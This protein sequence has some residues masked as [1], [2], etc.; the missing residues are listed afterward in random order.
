MEGLRAHG[1]EVV[2]SAPAEMVSADDPPEIREAAH[3]PEELPQKIFSIVPDVVI[4]EQWGLVTYLPAM[5]IPLAIDLHG[6]LSLENAFKKGGNFR[7][8]ALTKIDALARADLLIV[9]GRAQKQYFLTWALLGGADPLDPPFV[10]VPVSMD[11][12]RRPS[13]KSTPPR[14]VFGGATWPWIDPFDALEIAGREAGNVKGAELALYVGEPKL[15]QDHPLYEINKGIYADYKERLKGLQAVKHH[16]LIPHDKLLKVYAGSRA[17]MDVYRPNPERELAFSTRTVEY[18]RCGLPIITGRSMELAEPVERYD[19]GWVVDETSEKE[20]ADAVREALTDEGKARTKSANALRLAGALFDHEHATK[21]LAQWV[22]KPAI[23]K[24]GKKSLLSDFRDYYRRESVALIDKAQDKVAKI[25]EEM[26]AI[27]SEFQRQLA[28]KEDRYEALAADMRKRHAE[29]DAQI[30]A[31]TQEHQERLTETRRDVLR[32]QDKLDEQQSK[33]DERVKQ[34]DQDAKETIK[35]LQEEIRHL[36]RE[37]QADQRRKDQEIARLQKSSETNLTQAGKKSQQEI[38][39]RDRQIERLQEKI[40]RIEREHAERLTLKDKKLHDLQVAHDQEIRRLL[41]K[42]EEKMVESGKRSE[43]EIERRDR[44][45]EKMQD[46]LEAQETEH[47]AKTRDMEQET[48]A[49]LRERDKEMRTMK[50]KEDE[51]TAKLRE[52]H[53]QVEA[54]DREFEKQAAREGELKQQIASAEQELDAKAAAVE[55]LK[56]QLDELNAEIKS[57]F[58]E[59]DRVVS[60]KES[61][62]Q[63]AKER[64]DRLE[65]KASEQARTITGLEKGRSENAQ[66]VGTNRRRSGGDGQASRSGEVGSRQGPPSRVKP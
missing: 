22:A 19:A 3:V 1:H 16:G 13:K 58:I 24:K 37:K 55:T 14:L 27:S 29:H 32:L 34:L 10:V 12:V 5:D 20:I 61:F 45:I 54:K 11:P 64:F 28:A 38:V 50:A 44:Q 17:A 41:E 57:K 6:P 23:R 21:R 51:I 56:K 15:A 49:A 43:E 25:N 33:H 31:L 62:V 59:L 8:D 18:L 39:K 53:D 26:R 60:E 66:R 42:S 4:V 30:R 35:K 52:A 63:A 36:N 7:T 47:R 46:R 65:T 2:V 9:P 48:R 40:D